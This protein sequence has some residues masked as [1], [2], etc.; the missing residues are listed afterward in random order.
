[1]NDLHERLLPF[2]DEDASERVRRYV[3]GTGDEQFTGGWFDTYPLPPVAGSAVGGTPDRID[4]SDLIATTLLSIEVRLGS[5]S[6]FATASI[7]RLTEHADK[8][9]ALLQQLPN[10]VD[11]HTLSVER[12]DSLIGD[13]SSPAAKL[14]DLL[15]EQVGFPRVATFKLLARKRPRLLPIRDGDLTVALGDQADW[16][17]AWWQG[18][19]SNPDTVARLDAIRQEAE[20][21]S[22]SLLRTADIAVWMQQRSLRTASN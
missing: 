22:L 21:P 3:H 9:L 17:R 5:R 12:Y 11:L 10:D 2:L 18:L 13:E 19:S 1:M 7:L 16:W 8:V 20:T 14:W 15:R 4:D 6:G